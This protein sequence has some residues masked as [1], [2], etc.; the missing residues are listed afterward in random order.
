MTTKLG[1]K[2]NT[3]ELP[4][5][6][7]LLTLPISTN[8][9]HGVFK[10][11]KILSAKGRENKEAMA[12]EARQQYRGQPISAPIS[13]TVELRWPTRRNHDLDNIK[14]LLDAMTGILWDD[15]GQIEELHITKCYDKANPGV[16][17]TLSK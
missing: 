14:S 10:G 8:L 6:I 7:K 9:L 16:T 3:N 2:S 5:T 4:V 12:W 17:L 15:D 11:R 13:V 1:A